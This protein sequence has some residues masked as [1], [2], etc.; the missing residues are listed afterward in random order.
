MLTL[1][2]GVILASAASA[3]DSSD[4]LLQ[5]SSNDNDTQ[6]NLE[7]AGE[8]V[9]SAIETTNNSLLGNNSTDNNSLS[10]NRNLSDI[11]IGM[12]LD[13]PPPQQLSQNNAPFTSGQSST[14]SEGTY[15]N[16]NTNLNNS[17]NSNS[18]S[19]L[20]DPI[21]S[22]TV[23]LCGTNDPM[24]GVNVT[25][26]TIQDVLMATTLTGS[27][28][29]Y[30]V[31]FFSDESTF[32][33]K[34]SYPGH[35]SPIKLVNVTRSTNI[36]DLNLYGTVNFNLG[37]TAY[38][39]GTNGN[40]SWDGSSPT[41]DDV[42]VGPKKTIQAGVD[43]VDSGGYVY[44]STG[45]YNEN[46][47]ITKILT[48]Q[49]TSGNT[50]AVTSLRIQNN[51]TLAGGSY[52]NITGNLT[53]TNNS[54]L[55]ILSINNAGQVGGVWAGA[56]ST[57]RAGNITINAGSKIIADGQ[58][59]TGAT[60]GLGGSPD[61]N[62]GSY[63]GMGEG[64]SPGPTYG[65]YLQPVDLGSSGGSTSGNGGGAV[66]IWAWETLTNNGIISA[67]G[68]NSGGTGSGAGSGG[69]VFI[70]CTLVQGNGN[71]TANGGSG[72]YGGGGG[73][74]TIWYQTNSYTGTKT[75]NGGSGILTGQNGT[76]VNVLLIRSNVSYP[77][78]SIL[79]Y[80][81]V[82]IENGATVT[83]GGNSTFNVSRTLLIRGSST[84]LLQGKN[85]IAQVGGVW[86]G[87]GSTVYAG[88]LTVESGSKISA[89]SQGYTGGETYSIGKGPGGGPGVYGSLRSASGGGYGGV[90]GTGAGQTGG[91]S[92]YGSLLEPID[93]GSGGGGYDSVGS[94]GGGVVRII[95]GNLTVNGLISANGGAVNGYYCGAGSGGSIF[96][97]ANSF[98]GSGSLSANG[99]TI[100]PSG[101]GGGAGGGGRIAVYY[102]NVNFN[103]TTSVQGGLSNQG[104]NGA[105]GT[106]IFQD[107]LNDHLYIEETVIYPNNSNI[108]FNNSIVTLRNN[109][110]IYLGGNSTLNVPGLFTLEGNS[111]VIVQAKNTGGQVGGVWAG[112]GSTI[113]AGN[114]TVEAGSS[115]N[116]NG[117]GYIVGVGPG[118]GTYEVV[119]GSYGGRGGA[120]DQLSIPGPTYGNF[121]IP[122]DLGSG[123]TQV[124]SYGGSGGGAIQIN[125]TGTLDVRGTISANGNNADNGAG[126][127]GSVYITTNS[128]NG[129]GSITANGGN[130][131][132]YVKSGPGGG[133]RVAVYYQT[134]NYTGSVTA[135][136]GTNADYPAENGSVVFID[137]SSNSLYLG[138]N[139]VIPQDSLFSGY[140]NIIVQNGAVLTMGGNSMVNIPG[141][142]TVTGNSQIIILGKNTGGQ[143]GGQWLGV[144]VTIQVGNLNI[145]SGSKISADGQGYTG[146]TK[147]PGAGPNNNGGSY[148]GTGGGASPGPTY[149]SNK[150]PLDLGS[151]GGSNTGN[152]GGAVKIN[153]TGT[154]TNNGIISANGNSGV[155]GSGSGSGGSIYILTNFLQGNGNITAKG[156][157]VGYAGGGGRIAACYHF[158]TF[159]GLI[160]VNGGTG[161][162][163]GQIGTIYYNLIQNNRTGEFSNTINE[164]ISSSN[165]L[166]GDI[167]EI[168][169]GN[170][171]ES[172]L[173]N[174]YVIIRPKL[175]ASVI[176]TSLG[177]VLTITSGGSGSS[178]TNITLNGGNTGIY[179]DNTT[180]ILL[181]NLTINNPTLDGVGK[182]IN[183]V[184]NIQIINVVVNHPGRNGINL[185]DP[186]ELDLQNV[187]I[188]GLIVNGAV[189][190]GIYVN[191]DDPA[192]ENITIT[193]CTVTNSGH[194]GINLQNARGTVLITNNTI[195]NSGVGYYGAYLNGNSTT[196]NFTGNTV[197]NND[198]GVYVSGFTS[199]SLNFNRIYNNTNYDVYNAGPGTVDAR[200]NWWGSNSDPGSK[201]FGVT[202]NP[203]MILILSS[204]PT[205]IFV[206]EQSTV[207]ADMTH[208]STYN[209]A[210]P[211]AS[212]HDPVSGHIP[213]GPNGVVVFF[214]NLNA[215]LG[216]ITPTNR[217]II[218]G[219]ANTTFTPLTNLG[220]A[221]I[222]GTVDS[223]TVNTTVTIIDKDDIYIATTGND[224]T[225]IGSPSNP[226]NTISKGI[227]EVNVNGRVHIAN[228]TYSGLN[229]RQIDINKNITIIGE[230]RDT[231]VINGS[232]TAQIFNTL[233][234]NTIII[235]NLTFTQG[236]STAGWYGGA[237]YNRANLTIENCNFTNNLAANHGGAIFN[238]GNCIV[239]SSVF[240]NNTANS[241]GGAIQNQGNLT[242]N[243]STFFGNTAVVQGGAIVNWVLNLNINNS[244]F[245]NN[246]AG[247]DAGAI[248]NY[249]GI[250]NVTESFFQGN[251]ALS[252][253]AS[254]GLGGAI[255]NRDTTTINSSTFIENHAV[256]RGGAIF[257][258]LGS[259]TIHFSRI[260]GNTAGQGSAIYNN[261]VANATSNWWGTNNP[262]SLIFGTVSYDPWLVMN[263]TIS[264]DT[265]LPGDTSTITAILNQD[266]HHN[267]L[268]L[269]ILEGINV[270]FT[271]ISGNGNVS[272][273]LVPISSGT[274]TT[275]FT[276][277]A[278]GVANINITVGYQTVN[279][280]STVTGDDIYVATTG[281]DNTGNGS[282]GNPFQ[283]IN[284]G[285]TCVNANGRVHIANGTYS[286]TN[287]TQ[288]TINNNFTIIGESKV[289][290]IINGGGT[291]RVFIIQ[292]GNNVTIQ[293]LTFT[294]CWSGASSAGGAIYNSGN[295]T[296]ENCD[297]TQNSALSSSNGGAIYNTGIL[298]V[299]ICNFT[300]NIAT[301]DG[302]ITNT[303]VAII[304]SSSFIGNSGSSHSGAIGNYGNLT[305]TNSLFANDSC[306]SGGAIQ[307]D[308]SSNGGNSNATIINCTFFNCTAN[309]G[310]AIYNHNAHLS[311]DNCTFT[312]NRASS[313]EGGAIQN[314]MSTCD[315]NNTTF[316]ENY[317][318]ARG[319]AISFT[320]NSG[321]YLIMH[322]S[323]IGENTAT[324]GSAIY[325]STVNTAFS[326]MTSNWWGTNN[327][328]SVIYVYQGAVYYDPW[329]VMNSTISPTVIT[330]IS[331]AT[332]TVTLNKD[333]HNN[334]LIIPVL[335]GLNIDYSV[336]S[337]TG[338]VAQITA[339]NSSGIGTATF[340][341]SFDR[342]FSTIQASLD[343][344]N[345]TSQVEAFALD[346]YVDGLTGNDSFSGLTPA[347][348]KQHIQNAINV[349]TNGS[350]IYVNNSV[351]YAETL[352][353][354]KA[355]HI[356]PLTYPGPQVNLQLSGTYGI[357]FTANGGYSL[358]KGFNITGATYA[359]SLYYAN[360]AYNNVT[361]QDLTIQNCGMGITN[362]QVS[363]RGLNGATIRD[364]TIRNVTEGIYFVDTGTINYIKNIAIDNLTVENATNNGIYIYMNGNAASGNLSIFNS[365]IKDCGRYGIY[366]YMVKGT[367]D[368][369]N[370]LIENANTA[371]N[372]NYYGFYLRGTGTTAK[373]INQTIKNTWNCA[374]VENIYGTALEPFT[375]TNCTNIGT[376][377]AFRFDTVG[378]ITISNSTLT[379][380]TNTLNNGVF[381]HYGNDITI[382]NS[383]I[384]NCNYGITN[385]EMSANGSVINLL[386]RNVTMT[387]IKNYG[388]YLLDDNGPIR[389]ITIENMIMDR[390]TGTG[391]GIYIANLY[392]ADSGN[393]T[394]R[395]SSFTNINL[396]AV[397]LAWMRGTINIENTTLDN[398]NSFHSNSF[399]GLD[400]QGQA[401]STAS[402]NDFHI[403]NTW[404]SV[405]IRTI[406][407]TPSQ[408]MILSDCSNIGGT[409]G[410]S[411]TDAGY[412]KIINSI[413]QAGTGINLQN[414]DHITLENLTIENCTSGIA[415]GYSMN[416]VDIRNVSI[417]NSAS[418]GVHFADSTP[419]YTI[420][421]LNIDHLLVD[422]VTNGGSTAYGVRLYLNNVNSGNLTFTNSIIKNC[423]RFGLGLTAVN[424][425]IIVENI[426]ID[427][428]TTTGDYGLWLQGNNN[429][430]LVT[431]LSI[432]NTNNLG[433]FRNILG[434]SAH[435]IDIRNCSK[436]GTGV[437]FYLEN[438]GYIKFSDSTLYDPANTMDAFQ[439]NVAHDITFENLVIRNVHYAF[440][441][442]ISTAHY[443]DRITFSNVT[444]REVTGRV[445]SFTDNAANSISNIF[446]NNLTVDGVTGTGNIVDIEMTNNAINSQNVTITN[447]LFNNTIS[448]AL[449]LNNIRG[450][451]I[452]ENLTFLNCNTGHSNSFYSMYLDGT[453]N[454]ATVRNVSIQ[455]SWKSLRVQD[456][457]GTPAQPIIISNCNN[458]GGDYGIY[459]QNAG[460]VN[461]VNST[462]NDP[463]GT[464][465]GLDGVNNT[466]LEN[467]TIEN[468]ATG[469]SNAGG[470]NYVNIRN[471]T[472]KNSVNGINFLDS[473]PT[474]AISNLNIDNLLVDG[475]TGASGSYGVGIR[476]YNANSQNLTFTN[477][478]VKNCASYGVHLYGLRGTVNLENLTIDNCTSNSYHGLYLYGTNNPILVT[479][480]SIINANTCGYIRD[481][482]GTAAHPMDFRNCSKVGTGTAFTLYNVDYAKF[483]NST[484]Y[485][486]ANTMANAFVMVNG[487]NDIT[488]ENI[489]IQ[490]C[491]YGFYNYDTTSHQLNRITFNNVTV[492]NVTNRAISFSDTGA[493]AISNILINNFT[494]DGTTGSNYPI[495]INMVNNV[496]SQNITITNSLFTNTSTST[497]YL[498]NMRGKVILENLTFLN[499][500]KNH[501]NSFFALYLDGSGNNATVSNVS[502]QNSWKSAR[503]QE[504]SGTSAQPITFSNCT[505][506]G[507]DYGFYLNAV[508]YVNIVNSTLYDPA[509]AV[510]TGIFLA[511]VNNTKIQNV[512]IQNCYTGIGST[513]GP[514]NGINITNVTLKDVHDFGISLSDDASRAIKNIN[515]DHLTIDGLATSSYNWNSGI[516]VRMGLNAGSGNLTI[517]NSTIKNCERAGIYL[518]RVIGNVNIENNTFDN[519]NMAHSAY[520]GFYMYNSLAAPINFLRNTVINNWNGIF[521][522]SISSD[523]FQ[524]NRFFNNTN[525]N[526]YKTGSGATTATYNWW[527]TN[528]P[529]G[530]ITVNAGSVTYDPYIQLRLNS[531]SG[532]VFAGGST[533]LT[534]DLTHDNHNNVVSDVLVLNGVTALFNTTAGTFNPVISLISAGQATSLFTAP[535]TLG[536]YTVNTTVD[537]ATVSTTIIV[538]LIR[539]V[540]TNEFFITIQDAIN[541]V[542]TINGHT[543]EIYNGTYIENVNL[544]KQLT[545]TSSSGANATVQAFNSNLPVFTITSSGSFSTLNGLIITGA[546]SS[547]GVYLNSSVNSTLSGNNITANQYGIYLNNSQNSTIS[548]NNISN[549]TSFGISIHNSST[550]EFSTNTITGG[551]Y[552]LRVQGSAEEHFNQTMDTGNSINGLPVY[553]LVG[554][555]NL[556]IDGAS[557]P[558][559]SGIGYLALVSCNNI[560]IVNLVVSGNYTGLLL[561]FTNISTVENST[562]SNNVYGIFMDHTSGN[563]ITNNQISSN[564]NGIYLHNATNEKI[565]GNN[566][567]NNEVGVYSE[568]SSSQINF[569]RIINNTKFGIS[570]HGTSNLDALYNWWGKNSGPIYVDSGTEPSPCDIWRES[571][572]VTNNIWMIL[573][574]TASPDVIQTSQQS[575][576][577]ADMTHDSTYNPASPDASKHDPVSGHI[578]DGP[579]GVAVFFL[580]LNATLGSITPTSRNLNNGIANT[581]FTALLTPGTATIN[582]TVDNQTVNTTVTIQT[583]VTSIIVDPVTVVY[584]GV[585]H[586]SATLTSGGS[587]LA[588]KSVTFLID[589]SSV[590]FG[591]TNG[592]GVASY[593]YSGLLAGGIHSLSADF[594]GDVNYTASSATNVTGLTVNPAST[595]LVINPVTVVYGNTVHLS[596]TLTSGGSG[597][598]GESVNFQIDGASVGSGITNGS[599]EATYDYTG[600]LDG[601]LHSI[602]ANFA[603]DVNYTSSS[604]TNVTGLNVTPAS[605]LVVV[606]PVTVVYGGLVHLSATLTSG[607]IGLENKL[608]SFLVEGSVVGSDTT[609]S[610]GLVSYDYS[611]LL[612]GGSHSIAAQFA[613]DVNYTASSDTNA[614]GLT[615]TTAGTTLVVDPVN[616]V[617]GGVA[618]LSATLTSGTGLAGKSVTFLVD[619]LG[620][621]SGITNVLGIA[622]YDYSGL[623][624][625]GTHS[626]GAVFAGDA[627]YTTSSDTNST[628]LTVNTAATTII[629]DSVSVIYGN[630]VHLTAN[631]TSGSGLAGKLINFL[632]DGATVGSGTTDAFGLVSYD[633]TGLLNGGFHSLAANFAGDMNYTTSSAFNATGITVTPAGT[634]IVVN[635]LTV[636]YG[637]V[638]HLRATLTTGGSGLAS[639]TVTFL[640]NSSV[641]GTGSTDA[642]GIAFYDY[643]GILSGGTH[644]LTAQFA[645][646]VNYTSS[647]DT[648]G[649]GIA[650][651][652]ANTV[653]IINSLTVVYGNTVHLTATLTSI[654][655]GLADK[656]VNFLVDGSI[657]GSGTTDAS[658]LAFYDYIG[659]LAGG[660][661]SIAAQ[662]AGDTNYTSSSD[663]NVTG[664][665]VTP[666]STSMAVNPVTAVYGGTAHLTATLS[667]GSPLP[668]KT[669]TF[670]IDGSIVGTGSTDA[671]GVAFYDYSGLLSVGVHNLSAQFVGDAN[672]TDSSDTNVTG[673]IVAPEGTAMVVHPV[674]VVYGNLAHLTATLT[675]GGI[676]LASKSISFL[677]DGS[678]V[679]SGSTDASGSAF[680]DYTSLISAGSHSLT[681]QFAGDVNYAGSSDTNGTGLTVTPT[682][683][684][685]IVNPLTV[686]YGGV[687]HLTT[688]LTSGGLGLAGKLVSFLVDGSV[689]GSGSTDA[690]GLAF[691]DYNGMISVGSHI[692]A[693]QFTGDT[694]YTSSSD[695]NA[696]GLTV[697][698]AATLLVVNPVAVVY[699]NTIHITATL[700]N[701]GVGLENKLITFLVDGGVVG[702][703]TT[704][705]SGLAFYDYTGLMTGGSHSLTAQFAGDT[706]YTASSDTNATGLIVNTAATNMVVDPVTVVY[707]GV[708]HLSA[709]LTSGGSGLVGK[710]VSFLVD[711]LSVGSGITDAS[712][713][714][715]Y[716]YGGLLAG[717]SHSIAAQFVG[718]VNYTASSDTNATGLNVN[719]L[720]TNIVVD[721]VTVVYGNVAHL[722]A[723]LTSGGVGLENKLVTFLV[724]GVGV[725]SDTTDANGLAFYD[726]SGLLSG[727]SHSLTA[728]FNGDVNYT[729][730]SIT[731][732]TGLTVN[733]ASTTLVVDPV[734]II[735]GNVAHLT[736]TLTSSGSGLVGK[737]VTFLVD[738]STVGSGPTNVF[739]IAFYDYTGLI[740]SGA[741]SLTV[742]F[743]GD[744]NYT[745]SSDTN[746]TGLIVNTAATN[747]V[748]DP[749]T[750][751]Y[752]GVAHLSAT[753]TSGGSGLAGKL[754]TFLVDGSSVGS[755]T[756]DAS[757]IAFYD[758]TGLLNGGS[759][760][761]TAQ[762]VGDTNFTASS[763]TNATGLT[764]NTAATN[765]VVAPVTVVY[766]D[767][768]H[769]TATLTSGGSGLA[770]K[771]V[772]FLLDGSVVGSGITDASG[773][774]F[775]D[776]TGLINGGV[777]SIAAQFVG[778]VNYTASS[779]TNA[780]GL[781]V[782][783]LG[784]NIVVDPLTVVYGN[785]AHL[786][787]TLT[788]G[789]VGL[790]NKLVTFL[791][792]GG[793]VGSDT[794]DALGVASYDYSGLLAGGPHS[795]TAQFA[796]DMNHTASS[797]INTT[798]LTVNPAG[799]STVVDPV[800]VVYGNNAHLSATLTSGGSGLSGK[801][802]TFLLD[803]SVVGSGITDASGLAFYDY[804]G[805]LGGGVHSLGAQFAGDV[806]YTASADINATGLNVNPASTTLVVNPSNMIYG[807]I[808]HLTATLTSGGSALASKPI[809]FLVDGAI[810]GTG[811]TDA[812]GLAFYDYNGLINAGSH[813]LTAQFAG[814][815]N[816]TTS[817]NTNATGLTVTSGGTTLV[818]YPVTVVYGNTAHLSATLTS[819]GSGL[820]GKLV[821]FLLDGGVVGSG[822]SD[823]SGLAFYDYSGILGGGVHS[824]GA[825]FA[826]D[827]NYTASSDINATGLT[828]TPA[829]TNIV[830]A[831]ITVVYG[832]VVHLTAT[833]TTGGS[834]LV[835]K[836][837]TFIVDGASVGSNSTD[838]SGLAF[839]DYIGLL[840]GGSH[841]LTVQFAGDTN[842]TASSVTNAT[843]ITVNPAA[844]NMVVAPVTVI[845]G[846]NIHLTAILTSG[847]P[848]AGK[849]VSFLLDGVV[850]GSGNTDGSGLA[851]Y[852]YLGLLNAGFHS[853]TAQFAGDINYTSSS[854]TNLTGITVNPASTTLMI[855]P[856]VVVYG[857][858]V[859][860]TATLTSGTGLAS[861]LVTFLIDGS[862]VGSGTSDASGL[863]FYD[864]NGLI[865]AGSHIIAAQFAG[866]TNYTA[867]ANT[868]VTGLT[869]TPA[870]TVL[871]IDPVAVIYGNPVH[872]T[873][874]LTTGGSGLAG[875][876]VTFLVDGGVVGSDTTD[877]SGLAFYDYIGLLTGG[878]HSLGAEFAGDANYT[879]SANTN[880]TGLT[881]TP[882]GTVLV[883][884]PVAVIYGNPVH[885]TATLTTG[886]SGLAGKLV[887][888]LV[889]GGVV[890]SDTTDAGGL[891]FYD[892]TGLLNGG[893]H[894][895]TAQFAGDINYTSSAVTNGT[896]LIVN[897]AAS[898]MVVDP[899]TVIYG[900]T[901][902]LTAT[903]SSGVGLQGKPITFLIDGINIGSGTTDATGLA[904][905]NYS[906]LVAGGMHSLTAQFAG[907]TNY[908][909]SSATNAGG[910][911]VNPAVTN[912]VVSPV[913]VVYG[914]A[915][916]LTATL[917]SG[918][919]LAGKLIT[920]LVDGSVVGTGNTNASGLAFYDYN[921]LLS[922]GT[923]NLAAQFAG[924]VNSTSSSDTILNGLQ[925]TPAVTSLVVPVVNGTTGLT[926]T[927]TAI[928]TNLNTGT[929][930]PGKTITFL[931]DG[932]TLT[933][934]TDAT[935]R[936]QVTFTTPNVG[937]YTIQASFAGDVNY[938]LSTGSGNLEVRI[939]TVPTTIST[940]PV[941]GQK[942]QSTTLWAVLMSN[943]IP[944]A[945]KLVNFFINGAHAGS[946]LTGA[947]GR[948]QVNYQIGLNGG[949]Y[950]IEVRFNGDINSDPSY[951]TSTLTVTMPIHENILNV[952][953]NGG[954][955]VYIVYNMN[956][957]PP[958]GGSYKKTIE[959]LIGAGE[960]RS[961][962]LGFLT[963]GTI[964]NILPHV[965]DRSGLRKI[966]F[967][968][969]NQILVAGKLFHENTIFK[970]V[971]RIITPRAVSAPV[972]SQNNVLGNCFRNFFAT[973]HF[974]VPFFTT[975]LNVFG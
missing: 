863:A 65:D 596:A 965:Y 638:N 928:L 336:I 500:N 696:T 936:A 749:V 603:G 766:G 328:S 898:N 419:N 484:L 294:N 566:I 123:G 104:K 221:T 687:A 119:G 856:S 589:G 725:G 793:V 58:G 184:H 917:T 187:L 62:G 79:N 456:I 802:I 27:D 821:S 673:L 301:Y 959:G 426:T 877:A 437:A 386:L 751:V 108:T 505:N 686:V 240:Y 825:Q 24:P 410:F 454:T 276:A 332:M 63:S 665:N 817:S 925:V 609:D 98:N 728:Q 350:I 694:N 400:L 357:T 892:Y 417:R 587:G 262:S 463:S 258:T 703:G 968:L 346:Y 514:L 12:G 784:T 801:L 168:G 314:Y 657:V 440:D 647:S 844:T 180:D 679:G 464:G 239:L 975:L 393:V 964:I 906:E 720:G 370:N 50:F 744:A 947:D 109:G 39:D 615:V 550:N 769:L 335:N 447:S 740:A 485:D 311:I 404:Q 341:S 389:N 535:I 513:N 41:H 708:A 882:A 297:F 885:I 807:G 113:N 512:T 133:G 286:G 71:I 927:I 820:A 398:V 382:E 822:T 202:Y 442:W 457:S 723:T 100:I 869:V 147:G 458:I 178:I 521:I 85:T 315:I 244:T 470:L 118:K 68:A 581:T 785:L 134:K 896:G 498:D 798:G 198:N 2:V 84:L 28:G 633:Y 700:T 841:S 774:A 698:P 427:N 702:T 733:T 915:S 55:L 22:G 916:H 269:P 622:S 639:K 754:V 157:S 933:D 616:V 792:D 282:Q 333:N 594:A 880:V 691:Y 46:V 343:G 401:G 390:V 943:G 279:T 259:L 433:Y 320:G 61:N 623:L 212:R 805:L 797:A 126:S 319:G 145:D 287:N 607:G 342:G 579:N 684:S 544:N 219:T 929:P 337:G 141:N 776:Y 919:G 632:I 271:V 200:Y 836:L 362:F 559:S 955:T 9:N 890:G 826:G 835:G 284:T 44:V 486:P 940:G 879:A 788:S 734:T 364:V 307:N 144:G 308:G 808:A 360:D 731:N 154:L 717:G 117:Q 392:V 89:D 527:G 563:N 290:V 600:L 197:I 908:T 139:V 954:S 845:Y 682:S 359:I 222:N 537:G 249:V 203:W 11:F 395:N 778:D 672:Y 634:L 629:V 233:S 747:M 971:T 489:T 479:N 56:G 296:V 48:F 77:E 208:D 724:D 605:T 496:N 582:A 422:G 237:I 658:G 14:S 839:F 858:T 127:G 60:K 459:L 435:P 584:G 101:A 303:N 82:F 94:N 568:S 530:T 960:S 507:G 518:D 191:M 577:L 36:S 887:T 66:K 932:N 860:L 120:D 770:G 380:S 963:A 132:D 226:F 642:S 572:T 438:S 662:F 478:L 372:A 285:I 254:N 950:L 384:D 789:G 956:I 862:V 97:I 760:S 467:L 345:V 482:S 580:N 158:S 795:L 321:A 72:G 201:L 735:Y 211:D 439:F 876:L 460:Y 595:S 236:Y 840:A 190:D 164:I 420:N 606:D 92:T 252:T 838:V 730:S 165:T 428:C 495:Y 867:S 268:F 304:N 51:L 771:M 953:N 671:S 334:T 608:V 25:V 21:I 122:T 411:L 99:G 487:C 870:G 378:Y 655:T 755:G 790:E 659:S 29:R 972:Y 430:V 116:A 597:L 348:A 4:F 445:I 497:V 96:I 602:A 121:L 138:Q 225:G 775:Y 361:L 231:T 206:G 255:F 30:N 588:D 13:N 526:F 280:T 516:Y 592:S 214:L 70:I 163:N 704:D 415:N 261:A 173:V 114:L 707:G 951:N 95:A 399:Y 135:N 299:E 406:T 471:V 586:L 828:V 827:V 90:G 366:L 522:S 374:Y 69:S 571:G 368:I 423:V 325:I 78:N 102:Q 421:N 87:V 274:A 746:A 901:I 40:D 64:S 767:I 183:G 232:N 814:D 675:S 483:S 136:K 17:N 846:N 688:T 524:Y 523:I 5:N 448:N 761:L 763:D 553:Y 248:Y 578:P 209:P 809:I 721:P 681:A 365:H 753:L 340:T 905:Y 193:D 474:Y 275:T 288:I 729:A 910:I 295:L 293:N 640:I 668:N 547:F 899:L 549:S 957:Q 803:G 431:N 557:A 669:I 962:H 759:H 153:V 124:Y 939:P 739:G 408:Q 506:M 824:L 804:S 909:A 799:T 387:N 363:N 861:K 653:I 918:T 590:G 238:I 726:Y 886:G 253:G 593:N 907:D 891:A 560:Q 216:S 88:N 3:E 504:I 224:T 765:L 652:P 666:A 493:N 494:L 902:H 576:I 469:I 614:T 931:I 476:L 229:N 573:I 764:V 352:T 37:P 777:H 112:V 391:S 75:A 743:A 644:S 76:V 316:T 450:T 54:Q 171:N 490:N 758:L 619:G 575:T 45:T 712:G 416:N 812:S 373:V 663:T 654:G 922:V 227:T 641:V 10:E 264:P 875:K 842:Y 613:G 601:G 628:G 412:V 941:S 451:V 689:V 697:T 86:A 152:G 678:V 175:G 745:A 823:V 379:D 889:D 893:S 556:V 377:I 768:V 6:T 446:I 534:A 80:D 324:Q 715:F 407:G 501:S 351:T 532:T 508:N 693:A 305:L 831:P 207:I 923:H 554:Q 270:A 884:D 155:T 409:S 651:N 481:I 235:Q 49:P 355:V 650:V 330:P 444:V 548:G 103:G 59:Y 543:I 83:L 140:S 281:N 149:G 257:N 967:M 656:I 181:Q 169:S 339:I 461:I 462:I 452:L 604:D 868:N 528:S 903:L 349:A 31:A 848:L 630:T 816:H 347:T 695:T 779:V 128:L 625:G 137:T 473:N 833:L 67:N 455:N 649:T 272:P 265:I 453:G 706:N 105:E 520:A 267:S 664:L 552:G 913:N 853:L 260:A 38:V 961:F 843:G 1:A 727:G 791:V 719:T 196:L 752:G 376:G 738:G 872:I 394:I 958:D 188:Q 313:N 718:D 179:L 815:T 298:T 567:E 699:G 949:N 626:I 195:N 519:C 857:N 813:S 617:Y 676:G 924:D 834:N 7:L 714:A 402:F 292:N 674:S 973:V 829:A 660:V 888:F 167:I 499:C 466:L 921:G 570:V 531:S 781:N 223:Q 930:I 510:G 894:T 648:N 205:A 338:S 646:D 539:N 371:H 624:G 246:S 855:N 172:I 367:I 331:T 636:V 91:G 33:V 283:T 146:A 213:D 81:C 43:V 911:T 732:A 329:L 414:V 900:S 441:N 864:Y 74:V 796:G 832:N 477:S 561:A 42:L 748:V 19:N 852:D 148:G 35:V 737:L 317:A 150:A 685:L 162:I 434:T 716:N 542:N 492:K 742:Q 635:P 449:Y 878:V 538:R 598:A 661:H 794:T 643:N 166:P 385:D 151:S 131:N 741:H 93:L 309:S 189:E 701:G 115:I 475:V 583:S 218:N 670:L 865:S 277:T 129:T 228:G 318:S 818:V 782:N 722:T 247:L 468:C 511:D 667:S 397:N 443:L 186:P 405:R 234:G 354:N 326:N 966:T 177:D 8:P 106:K 358:L 611:G 488:F 610:N 111:Q 26:Y 18:S 323:R 895:L 541:A 242:V 711:G 713:I 736:A 935:G 388:M 185:P 256:N 756:T 192:S 533:T 418:Y 620:V 800:T 944:Q 215:T 245:I 709:T 621:G 591:I 546:S 680:Y 425:T 904:F 677:V 926:I 599:G 946:M 565:T 934:D 871:V 849:L 502:I 837:V 705:N 969:T 217:N 353:I 23:Y 344:C 300:Q 545:I 830:L 637:G 156:G 645:G 204:S 536:T 424:G 897:T 369:E 130:S 883:I 948:A 847:T 230:N 562:F 810:V 627:N 241:R 142:L 182:S 952:I 773:L 251:S 683:T 465:I 937:N 945:G 780:T 32:K 515:I 273:A 558:Y 250:L 480:V 16:A 312:G 938:T 15:N 210:T 266:N 327:P 551:Q 47:I 243:D 859:H 692:L 970:T 750:V 786:T 107:T 942:G 302:A 20:V 710:L 540:N 555:N 517:T 310:G 912:M 772:S 585:A 194:N 574:L 143:V 52:I 34:A 57:V 432:S 289:G 160:N 159:T 569:N 110:V 783:T 690:S 174:K 436:V 383:A 472:I 851:F 509:N 161:T 491:G 850:V 306:I 787:A 612:A 564:E 125:V 914:A 356:Q 170:F 403:L 53:V 866:D 873:A 974:E 176:V 73:R 375:F 413:M 631:L 291:R 618:H 854:D 278:P 762:F 811:T 806:N 263:S 199:A 220:T 819:G 322:F 525:Y 529:A 874:T 396:T 757:G 920:F 429:P 381:I 881:V 503:V